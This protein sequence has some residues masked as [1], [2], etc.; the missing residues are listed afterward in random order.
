MVDRE[1]VAIVTDALRGVG[2][3][4]AER[5]GHDGAAVVVNYHPGHGT[6]RVRVAGIGGRP[7]EEPTGVA[8]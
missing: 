6:E 1:R 2:R 8:R 4:V 7:Q 5:L 3:D